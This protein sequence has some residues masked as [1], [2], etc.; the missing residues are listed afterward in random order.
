MCASPVG[1][2]S[3]DRG[4]LSRQWRRFRKCTNSALLA[5][6][7]WPV[8]CGT[9]DEHPGDV[10]PVVSCCLVH[11]VLKSCNCFFATMSRR[12]ALLCRLRMARATAS[13]EGRTQ[14]TRIR[15]LALTAI[16]NSRSPQ[17]GAAEQGAQQAP[18]P[19]PCAARALR[20]ALEPVPPPEAVSAPSNPPRL[21]LPQLS[22]PSP[23]GDLYIFCERAEL[24]R[25]RRHAPR[26]RARA[27]RPPDGA[28]RPSPAPC[29]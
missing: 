29:R 18:V 7:N 10:S 13:P 9:D 28:P 4:T 26:R 14:W 24:H 20:P 6:H 21:P 12:F 17:S 15:L 2:F 11:S 25:R 16:L 23:R 27:C 5:R 19:G 22:S 3:C 1:R 8:C